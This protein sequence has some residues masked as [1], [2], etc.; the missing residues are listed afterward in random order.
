MVKMNRTARDQFLLVRNLPN[1]QCISLEDD[2][3]QYDAPLPPIINP[4]GL[5]AIHT[6]QTQTHTSI[7]AMHHTWD[8]CF[9]SWWNLREINRLPWIKPS[10][11]P[12]PYESSSSSSSSSS[13]LSTFSSACSWIRLGWSCIKYE[14]GVSK[15]EMKRKWRLR[16]IRWL[17]DEAED[18]NQLGEDD[19]HHADGGRRP[20]R[21]DG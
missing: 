19:D 8:H 18:E 4:I 9:F 12:T 7:H 13:Q 20:H 11:Q 17:K 3:M 2:A 14:I 16:L 6:T 1:I 15:G 21:L 5:V 10:I